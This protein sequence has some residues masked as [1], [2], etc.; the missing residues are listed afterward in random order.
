MHYGIAL[1]DYDKPMEPDEEFL[2][3]LEKRGP[4][5]LTEWDGARWVHVAKVK[6]RSE[7]DRWLAGEPRD[8]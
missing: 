1:P 6:E 3:E 7:L 4:W 8:R 2:A 5:T